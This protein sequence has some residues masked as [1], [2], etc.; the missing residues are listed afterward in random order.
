MNSLSSGRDDVFSR[1]SCGLPVSVR[2]TCSPS[3]VE[4]V[5]I[6]NFCSIIELSRL[7]N[8]SEHGRSGRERAKQA[9]VHGS[10]PGS[11]QHADQVHELALDRRALVKGALASGAGLA[12]TAVF[13]PAVHAAKTIKLGYVSPQTGPLAAFAEADNFV[14]LEFL[15]TMQRRPQDRQRQL[16]GRGRGQGQPVQPEPRRRGGAS[17]LIVDNKIDL[18]LVAS[19]PETT[20]P[21]STQCEI[22]E[23]PCVSTVAPW[24]PYFI[25][26]QAES[27]R[28]RPPGSRSTT[29]STSSGGS[30]TSSPSSP[31]C[32]ASSRPTNRSA[33]SSRTTATA[34]PGATSR[35]ASRRCSTSSA[36]S[37]PIPAAT[38]TSPTISP[39]R[40][41]PS[42]APTARSSPAWCCRPTSPRSGTRRSQ[43]GFKPKSASVGKALLFPVAVEALGRNGNNLSSEVWWSPSHPFKSSLTG[44]SARELATAYEQATRQA[45]DP[46]DRLR[47]RAVR[48]RGRR[49]QA[50]RREERP[51]G[52]R[53]GDRRD[54][55]RHHRRPRRVERDRNCRH[56]RRR[57]SPR[58]R[59]SAASG[60]CATASKYDIVITDNKTAPMIPVGGKME[61]IG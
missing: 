10:T 22:E 23:V 39:R 2:L 9:K 41:P 59:S 31:T 51:Q 16:S 13:A 24:Q 52:G 17:E 7:V 47:A 29:P 58:R 27:G 30:R 40:S 45:V 11:D 56:S 33:A 26:R 21:V 18:M 6:T 42:S 50:L 3:A 4:D 1:V 35:S 14:D 15:D 5:R 36:T 25:G 60:G 20:N 19:T 34:T 43:Q 28:V 54:Q 12:A 48:G 61:P 32:G 8:A 46:A 37:S 55:A 49:A 44:Q 57:T 38:R 53:R